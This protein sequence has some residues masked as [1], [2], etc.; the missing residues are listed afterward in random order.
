MRVL[1][2]VFITVLAYTLGAHAVNPDD[3]ICTCTTCCN[4]ANETNTH[5]TGK[6]IVEYTYPE[7]SYYGTYS[8]V[9]HTYRNETD[10]LVVDPLPY[11]YV[12]KYEN[13]FKDTFD[14]NIFLFT[15]SGNN[16]NCTMSHAFYGSPDDDTSKKIDFVKHET[17]DYCTLDINY[18]LT[19]DEIAHP[20]EI[21]FAFNQLVDER[22]EFNIM[23]DLSAQGLIVPEDDILE[24]PYVIGDDT[25]TATDVNEASSFY[26]NVGLDVVDISVT[27]PGENAGTGCLEIDELFN[28]SNAYWLTKTGGKCD[29]ELISGGTGDAA[30]GGRNYQIRID[31]EDY[32]SCAVKDVELLNGN[33]TFTFRLVLPIDSEDTTE[34]T[35]SEQ[36][37]YF[38]PNQNVQNITISM[39]QDV[40]AEIDTNF[41]SNF[42]TEVVAV[43]PERCDDPNQ[44]P[45]PHSKIKFTIN[46]TFPSTFGTDFESV[47]LPSLEG[48]TVEWDTVTGAQPN[49]IPCSEYP[50][51]AGPEDD[52]K[53]CVFNLRTTTCEPMYATLS[54]NSAFERNTT[55]LLTGFTVIEEMPGGQ[56]ATYPA[57]DL[58]LGLDNLEFDPSFVAPDAEN[59][60]VNVV[61]VFNVELDLQNFYEGFPVDWTETDNYTMNEDMIV[62]LSVGQVADS[63][64]DFDDDL[65]LMIKTVTVELSNPVTND[66]ITSYSWSPGEKANFMDYSWSPYFSDP[67]FCTWY[68]SEATDKCEKFFV[69][70]TRSN[71]YHDTTWIADVMPYECQELGTTDGQE[72]SNNYDYFLFK[73]REWFRD[74][75]KGLVDMKVTVT[76]IIHKCSDNPSRLLQA[77]E[78][79]KIRGDRQLQSD[80]IPG[81]D[82]L[83]VSKDLVISFV[84]KEN[85]DS[86]IEVSNVPQ[87][88]WFEENKTLV[89]VASV[90]G[91]LVLLGCVVVLWGNKKRHY[92][93]LVGSSM[94]PDF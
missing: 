41:I 44:Y 74:N 94:G 23:Y 20:S 80:I 47:T 21:Y 37:R 7:V 4:V 43:S 84:T 38:G 36:C 91:G 2:S 64:F 51:E 15:N 48:L 42:N 34:T 72:D 31:Q 8:I 78:A 18:K 39:A 29:V 19:R 55:R 86:H 88:T 82:V 50:G 57:G 33:L 1:R 68:N 61:D 17:E 52:Y 46:A 79:G 3:P 60:P 65:E 6:S 28:N 12:V 14:R 93:V 59:P 53:V 49:Q 45:T 92:G 22:S 26:I 5:F 11:Q 16:L 71:N 81:R 67:R 63:P 62:R 35:D 13:S 70:G 9:G 87:K 69:D 54:G 85:G 76:G 24:Y 25:V 77:V 10:D 56:T 32:Q 73:P 90:L 89:I 30:D 66:V 83:Y 40:T 58:N 27:E 75:T